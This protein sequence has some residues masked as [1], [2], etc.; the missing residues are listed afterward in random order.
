[1]ALAVQAAAVKRIALLTPFFPAGDAAAK[2]FLEEAGIEVVRVHQLLRDRADGEVHGAADRRVGCPRPRSARRSGSA[3]HALAKN[4][5]KPT[6]TGQIADGTQARPRGLVPIPHFGPNTSHE[7][8]AEIRQTVETTQFGE[9]GRV[10]VS[11]G[12]SLATPEESDAQP[13]VDR[14]D[15]ALYEA[16]RGGRNAVV[17]KAAEPKA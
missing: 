15:A 11:I 14:A 12:V 6:G 9:V 7:R 8:F 10:T 3:A 2:A 13:L 5:S 1:M 4:S 16:K 17:L